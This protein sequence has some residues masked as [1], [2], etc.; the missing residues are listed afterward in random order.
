MAIDLPAS[1]TVGQIHTSGSSSWRW[2]GTAWVGAGG[3]RYTV[4]C[5]APGV[6]SASQVLL[7]HTYAS[8]VSLES[9]LARGTAAATASAVVKVQKALAASPTS[10]ADVGTITFGAGSI[11]GTLAG[12][13]ASFAPG[14]TL[15][16]L[17]PATPDATL[18]GISA[19]LV[20]AG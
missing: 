8:A 19:T 10:F 13:P 18:A 3:G 2:T 15:Q 16:L 6:P 1:P 9:G 12:L 5:Y 14:D 17:A 20:G 11:S 7:Q 4:A